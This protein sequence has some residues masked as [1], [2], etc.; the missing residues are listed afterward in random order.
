MKNSAPFF[1]RKSN[2]ILQRR[3]EKSGFLLDTP[4]GVLYIH[5]TGKTLLGR[6]LTSGTVGMN[7]PGLPVEIFC[8]RKEET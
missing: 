7:Q 6:N 4:P 2:S 8:R 1:F 3:Q 5:A